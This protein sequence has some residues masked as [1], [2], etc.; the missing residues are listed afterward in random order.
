MGDDLSRSAPTVFA[1]IFARCDEIGKRVH[2]LGELAFA[3]PTPALLGVATHMRERTDEA[4]IDKLQPIAV[5]RGGDREA[6][7]AVAIEQT[8]RRAIECDILAVKK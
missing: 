3:I 5:E 4:T 6:V 2:L 1:E 8:G 7:G